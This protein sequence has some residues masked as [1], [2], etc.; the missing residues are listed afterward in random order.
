MSSLAYDFRDRARPVV[1]S[2]WQPWRVQAPTVC[3]LC[4]PVGVD[5]GVAV[6]VPVVVPVPDVVVLLGMAVPLSW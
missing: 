2:V 1:D 3:F 6:A 5:V 4:G